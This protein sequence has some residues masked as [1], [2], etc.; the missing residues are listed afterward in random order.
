[1]IAKEEEEGRNLVF[2]MDLSVSCIAS[3]SCE[4]SFSSRSAF[5]V[6]TVCRIEK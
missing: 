3:L 6:S 2:R 1:M 4:I 5:R